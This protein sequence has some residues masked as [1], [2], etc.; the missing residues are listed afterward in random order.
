MDEIRNEHW[1]DVAEKGD[2]QK[3]ISALRWEVYIKEKEGF[4]KG[5]SSVFVPHQKQGNIVWTCVR[6]NII[7]KKEE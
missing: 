5:A 4:I 7:Y 1:R 6:D 2:D 3:K